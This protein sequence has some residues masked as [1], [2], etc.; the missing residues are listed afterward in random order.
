MNDFNLTDEEVNHLGLKVLAD[1]LGPSDMLRF[2]S[3]Y[4]TNDEDYTE[5]RHKW[6]KVPSSDTLVE[7]IAGTYAAEK[8]RRDEIVDSAL[9]KTA[10]FSQ[11]EYLA[12][13]FT[14]SASSK[15]EAPIVLLFD[16]L[17]S[18]QNILIKIKMALIKQENIN[19]EV[20]RQTSMSVLDVKFGSFEIVLGSTD[21]MS[22]DHHDESENG[23]PIVLDSLM[24][25]FSGTYR[26]LGYLT[27]KVIQEYEKFLYRLNKNVR[28]VE[29]KRTSSIPSRTAKVSIGK[30]DMELAIR[31]LERIRG[32]SSRIYQMEGTLTGIW[33]DRRKRFR[34]ASG[35]SSYE[36]RISDDVLE[37]I[38][39]PMINERY[40]A[41]IKETRINNR[42][43]RKNMNVKYELIELKELE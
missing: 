13:A 33:L 1:K 38:E 30:N 2:M 31:D 14:F 19:N 40:K 36:G 25:L 3:Q 24:E 26:E 8:K 27:P 5:N 32:E 15:G 21:D 18:L 7:E 23:L 12:L 39:K 10:Q 42:L 28:R 41:S 4:H 17:R 34:F 22:P 11:R 43:T 20:K 9:Q 35:S 6:V 37:S 29:V 16:L